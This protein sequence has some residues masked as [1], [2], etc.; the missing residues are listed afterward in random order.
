MQT[1]GRISRIHRKSRWRNYSHETHQ[2]TREFL[3]WL[4]NSQLLCISN[5]PLCKGWCTVQLWAPHRS[6]FCQEFAPQK[7]LN[8]RGVC[9]SAT[10]DGTCVARNISPLAAQRRKAA[11]C[12][13]DISI[14]KLHCGGFADGCKLAHL[15]AWHFRHTRA[16]EAE[17]AVERSQMLKDTAATEIRGYCVTSTQA[18]SVEDQLFQERAETPLHPPAKDCTASKTSTIGAESIQSIWHRWNVKC[19][20]ERDTYDRIDHAHPDPSHFVVSPK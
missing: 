5:R 14:T 17:G 11:A 18:L 8:Q 9:T 4:S 6:P 15:I 2:N 19:L 12:F 16:W 13:P 7:C 3:K 20:R 10:C 1:R